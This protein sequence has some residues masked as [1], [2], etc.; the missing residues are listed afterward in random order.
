MAALVST[1]PALRVEHGTATLARFVL[2]G[3]VLPLV[4]ET[5]P[6]AEQARRALLGVGRNILQEGDTTRSERDVGPL[7]P[8]FWGKDDDGLPRRGHRHAFFLPADEDGDGRLDHLTVFAPMGFS[9]LEVH[10]LNRFRRLTRGMGDGLA[11]LRVGLG[12]SRDFSAPLLREATEW[13]SATPFLVTRYPKTRGQKRDR[14]EE[15]ASPAAFARHVLSQELGRRPELPAVVA[16]E[17][18]DGIGA[19]RLRPLKFVRARAKPGDDG[20]RRPAAAFRITFATPLCGPLCLGHSCHFGL[21][22]FTLAPAAAREA[23]C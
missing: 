7:A 14:P 20:A 21:G 22:L 18:V 12:G 2:D 15:Y 6:V 9:P 3:A 23:T 19:R 13:V 1:K 16:I 4:T 17:P 5:L 10:A 11:L 8:A